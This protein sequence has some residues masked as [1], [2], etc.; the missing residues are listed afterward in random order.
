MAHVYK[1]DEWQSPTG[2]WHCNDV[3][4]LAG[5]SGKWWVPARMLG[6]SLTDYILLL[7]D[8][9]KAD[10]ES[11]YEPT[12]VLLF[13]WKKQPLSLVFSPIHANQ[14]MQETHIFLSY[15]PPINNFSNVCLCSKY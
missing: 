13:S 7:K 9:F 12:D 1:V 5:V 11:Y 8:E 15:I 2:K 10:I 3:K 6:M 14:P 4:D